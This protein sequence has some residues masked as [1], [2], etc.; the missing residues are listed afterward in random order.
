MP[1][2]DCVRTGGKEM[3][4]F[5]WRRVGRM[6]CYPCK[7]VS[8]EILFCLEKILNILE[9]PHSEL[10]K[11][12]RQTTTSVLDRSQIFYQESHW[13]WGCNTWI[14]KKTN[15]CQATAQ[16][17]SGLWLEFAVV[18][19]AGCLCVR[20]RQG[21]WAWCSHPLTER[22]PKKI[23]Y[24]LEKNWYGREFEKKDIRVL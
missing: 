7:V 2:W 9:Q 8:A 15:H 12:L 21:V 3:A 19:Q 22:T 16:L 11:L 5:I 13:H 23:V 6:R 1:F 18:M 17:C 4:T 20:E 10:E 14:L 24:K